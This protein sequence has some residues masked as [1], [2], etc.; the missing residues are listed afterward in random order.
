MS[1]IPFVKALGDEIERMAR[2]SR[3]RRRIVIGGLLFAVLATGVAAASGVFSTTERL[4]TAAIACY[5]QPSFDGGASMLDTGA[6]TP[7]ET[8]RRVQHTDGPLIACSARDHVAVFPSGRRD[9][10]ERL[11]LEPLPR[12]YATARARVTALE[13]DVKALEADCMPPAEFAR[14]LQALLDRSPGWEGWRAHRR[15]D[16]DQGP[17]GFATG[18]N[19]DGS[20]SL[21]G[22]L[23]AESRRVIVTGDVAQH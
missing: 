9:L 23:D 8:C 14:R 22:S 3:T 20:R 12:E 13:R 1:E 11:G 18:L 6:A 4:A 2:R 10:C 17:C 16:L 7:V 21:V 15:P 19:G 5:D